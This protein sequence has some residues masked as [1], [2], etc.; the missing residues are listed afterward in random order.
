MVYA[1]RIGIR[2]FSVSAIM[3]IV[4]VAVLAMGCEDGSMLES[5]AD[6]GKEPPPIAQGMRSAASTMIFKAKLTPIS[7]SDVTGEAII[8][9]KGDQLNVVLNARGLEASVP[10]AQHIHSGARCDPFSPPIVSL[11][12]DIS[13]A[14]GNATNADPGDDRF[15][16][17][18][19][20]GTIHYQGSDT[21]SAI[22]SALG[23]NLDLANRIV[24]VHAAGTPIGPPAACGALDKVG[25]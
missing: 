2:R 14:P 21:K 19:P 1:T 25:P 16:V 17:A 23:E 8:R 22:E 24:V 13:N 20:G 7:G 6:G 9:V 11:D 5:S 12:D 3:G 4:V 15:P 10:H 18:N